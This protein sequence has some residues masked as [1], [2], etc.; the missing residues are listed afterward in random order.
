MFALDLLPPHAKNH[1]AS[2]TGSGSLKTTSNYY[3]VVP[4]RQPGSTHD[5]RVGRYS[6]TTLSRS[7]NLV[8]SNNSGSRRT[9]LC[10]HVVTNEVS[11]RPGP[12]PVRVECTGAELTRCAGSLV[13]PWVRDPWFAKY[14]ILRFAGLL[15]GS[16]L[17]GG[18]RWRSFGLL[19]LN[20]Q[21]TQRTKQ[22]NITPGS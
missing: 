4:K 5:G 18:L 9:P 21:S 7:G 10:Y 15:L 17:F 13:R 1:L 20:K 3:H 22:H 2:T 12:D 6:T 8:A 19:A 11:G 16:F 14:S